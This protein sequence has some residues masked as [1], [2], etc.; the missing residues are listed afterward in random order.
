MIWHFCVDSTE[1]RALNLCFGTL[2]AGDSW[3]AVDDIGCG[4]VYGNIGGDN[5][6]SVG[7]GYGDGDG[8]GYGYGNGEGQ[9]SIQ[10]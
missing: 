7:D 4:W 8:D 2:T 3:E 6:A 1:K 9:S 5:D 10:W